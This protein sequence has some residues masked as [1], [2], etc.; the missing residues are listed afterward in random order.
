MTTTETPDA[1]FQPVGGLRQKGD[2]RARCKHRN[3][4]GWSRLGVGKAT[5]PSGASEIAFGWGATAHS[6]CSFPHKTQPMPSRRSDDE[7]Q[8]VF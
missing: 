8:G 1:V 3:S 5:S 2:D 6:Y 7:L 4:S